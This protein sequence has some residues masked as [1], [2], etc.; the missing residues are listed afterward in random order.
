MQASTSA[1]GEIPQGPRGGVTC[2]LPTVNNTWDHKE[3][4]MA[5]SASYHCLIENHTY[6]A[7]SLSLIFKVSLSVFKLYKFHI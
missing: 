6:C 3:H 5:F 4:C 1:A 2:P 7:K